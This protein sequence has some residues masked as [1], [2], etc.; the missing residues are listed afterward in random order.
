MQPAKTHVM[1][2]TDPAI[3]LR[4]GSLSTEPAGDAA[5]QLLRERLAVRRRIALDRS[6]ARPAAVLVPLVAGEAGSVDLL[7]FERTHDVLDHK[8]EICMP[9]GS[10]DARDIDAV[11]AALREANEELGI[12]SDSVNVLGLLDDVPTRVS[13]YVITPVVGF[14]AAPFAIVPDR[15][16]VA[17]P[18][19]V[20]LDQLLRGGEFHTETLQPGGQRRS[21]YSYRVGN[22]RI[23]GA[24]AR[25]IH[26]L[27]AVW[28]GV[29][30]A[31]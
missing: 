31:A 10:V 14:I 9:G 29:E 17:R 11:A 22:D 16:E 7:C 12:A 23:W 1:M 2:P 26:A 3:R 24:T 20:P 25:I 8:G 13:N 4:Y 15:L 30:G 28:F 27:L 21:S 18:L 19:S 6:T 5:L